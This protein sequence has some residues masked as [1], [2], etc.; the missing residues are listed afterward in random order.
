MIMPF[1]SGHVG[2]STFKRALRELKLHYQNAGFQEVRVTLENHDNSPNQV[3]LQQVRFVIVEGPRTLVKTVTVTGNEEI[4]SEKIL[5]DVLTQTP[6]LFSSGAFS[7]DTLNQDLA[8]LQRLYLKNGFLTATIQKSLVFSTDMHQVDVTLT[9]DEGPQTMVTAVNFPPDLPIPI[10]EA[11]AAIAL[12]PGSAYR[13]YMLT[14]DQNTLAGLISRSRLSLCQR[15][16]QN[17]RSAT[18]SAR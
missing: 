12:K 13:D 11:L 6:G 17:Q 3:S 10:S 4:S 2:R 9:I 8:A 16:L 15:C 14:S 18:I 5:A 1:F 7:P